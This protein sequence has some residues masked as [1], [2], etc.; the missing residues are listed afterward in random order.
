MTTH[1]SLDDLSAARTAVLVRS[2]ELSPTD[3]LEAAIKRIERRNPSLNAL[4]HTGFDDARRVAKKLERRLA[5]GEDI[6]I[7]A[8]VPTVMKDLFGEYPGWPST[9]GGIPALKNH[10]AQRF[11]LFPQRM[12]DA[13]AIVLGATNSPV[14]GFRGTCDNELFGPTRNPF[15]VSRNSGGSSGGS[16]A[17]VADGMLAVAGANDGG[18]S[19]RIPAAWCG[20]YGFQPS[21][22]TVPE[23]VRP[24]G[25]D[26]LSPY[27]YDG[28]V[29]RTVEDAALALSALTT[30]D[31]SDPLSVVSS[32]D[33]MAQLGRSVAGM[34]IGLAVNLG[35]F[36]VDAKV[37]AAV[38]RAAG[39][40]ERLGA[41][42]TLIDFPL[43]YSQQ[44]LSALWCTLVAPRMLAG[45]NAFASAGVDLR[46]P[47]QLPAAVLEWIDRARGISLAEIHAA[48]IVRT[49]VYDAF[50]TSFQ[51]VDL[52]LSAT[53]GCMPVKNLAGGKTVGPDSIEGEPVDPLIGWALTYLT[54][55]TGHPAASI[56]VGLVDGLPLG[57]Q[58]IGRRRGDGDVLA[59][60]AAFEREQ[61]WA[62]IYEVTRQRQLT[63]TAQAID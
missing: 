25:F 23:A 59:A 36:P 62:P 34:K 56:P 5:A 29:S 53:V 50:E 4:V 13:G 52:L 30:Y 31:P 60:S 54:N 19:I 26:N 6:G 9:I 58:I 44:E 35:V 12:Q 10:R 17:A 3:A 27:I 8:G 28:P 1:D 42:V 51:S 55:F 63:P 7:L 14:L 49:A 38:T 37:A 40:F 15:D 41:H 57:M 47:G 24:N 32:L 22:G 33:W 45:I 48:Q 2:G 43:P 20:V 39:V 46:K 61:P 16:T 18:G 11:S 21:L